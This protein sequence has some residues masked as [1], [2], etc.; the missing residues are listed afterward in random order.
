[1]INQRF[2]DIVD[3]V[4]ELVKILNLPGKTILTT[5]FDTFYD[6]P[7]PLEFPLLKLFSKKYGRLPSIS[8]YKL[9]KRFGFDAFSR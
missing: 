3:E 4:E 7:L 6:D 1:M 9:I 2:S 5:I 8:D